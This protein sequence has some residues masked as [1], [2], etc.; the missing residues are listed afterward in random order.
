MLRYKAELVGVRVLVSEE[1]YTST[2]SFLDLEP[3]GQHAVY[4]GKRVKPGLFRAAPGA[5]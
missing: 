1:S 5:A 3:I 4:A 2:C